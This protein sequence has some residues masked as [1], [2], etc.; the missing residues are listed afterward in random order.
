M[1]RDMVIKGLSCCKWTD[2]GLYEGYQPEAES[3]AECP[4]NFGDAA[5]ECHAE[6]MRDA[7]ELL[8]GQEPVKPINVRTYR[9]MYSDIRTGYCPIC[10]NEIEEGYDNNF[11]CKCGRAVKWDV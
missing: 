1:V 11:C 6:L 2:A 7:L 9:K 4:Y 8:K 5:S 3:C 10:N